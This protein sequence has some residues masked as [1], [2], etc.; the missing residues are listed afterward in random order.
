M[1]CDDSLMAVACPHCGRQCVLPASPPVAP[2]VVSPVNHNAAGIGVQQHATLA[3][4]RVQALRQRRQRHLI[5]FIVCVVVC[6]VV[7]VGF[8]GFIGFLN[9]E[10]YRAQVEA[11]EMLRDLS[12]SPQ[13]DVVDV[14]SLGSHKW[15]VTVRDGYSDTRTV[16]FVVDVTFLKNG[17]NR[18]LVNWYEER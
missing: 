17:V 9:S 14:E 4:Q 7:A 3:A 16:I 2:P 12:S 5:V 1:S 13:I 11:K 15:R 6:A 18:H 8:V 10:Y